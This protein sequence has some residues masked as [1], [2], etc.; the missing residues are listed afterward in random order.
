MTGG[1]QLLHAPTNASN[2]HFLRRLSGNEPTP[3]AVIVSRCRRPKK[4]EEDGDENFPTRMSPARTQTARMQHEKSFLVQFDWFM[5]NP[6]ARSVTARMKR[7]AS[8]WASTEPGGGEGK[9]DFEMGD[10]KKPRADLEADDDGEELQGDLRVRV[11][12]RSVAPARGTPAG[13]WLGVGIVVAAVTTKVLLRVPVAGGAKR[14]VLSAVAWR[15]RTLRA[16][17]RVLVEGERTYVSQR[18]MLQQRACDV[19][20]PAKTATY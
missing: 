9:A 3:L 16:Y 15:V 17:L 10:L 8:R 2:I 11:A 5:D 19:N 20:P 14:L 13:Q 4:R 6:L 12:C 1:E 7:S 18:V